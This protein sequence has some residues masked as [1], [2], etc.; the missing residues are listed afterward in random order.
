MGNTNIKEEKSQATHTSGEA[1]A[2]HQ[3]HPPQDKAESVKT[4]LDIF[5]PGWDTFLK[6]KEL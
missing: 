2:A 6:D 4:Y 5:Y 1:P 3:T